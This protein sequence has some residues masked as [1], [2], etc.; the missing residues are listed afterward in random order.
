[1]SELTVGWAE[2][3]I[4]PDGPVTLSGQYY[5]RT[6]TG[7][8]SRLKAVVLAMTSG[9]GDSAVM[10][11]MDV[12]AVPA[13][14]QQQVRERVQELEPEINP[15]KLFLN[16]THTHSAPALSAIR[17]WWLTPDPDCLDPDEYGEMACEKIAQAVTEAW[18]KRCPGGVCRAQAVATVGHCRRSVYADGHA[19]MYG[20]TS[21]PDFTGME[22]NED[23]T[24]EL[25]VTVDADQSPTGVILN[26]SCPSQVMEATYEISSDY[27]GRVRELLKETFGPEFTTLCQIGAA[28]CQSPR[29]LVRMKDHTFWSAAGV[30]ILAQRIAG[31]VREPITS[32]C[33]HADPSPAFGHSVRTL[34]LPMRLATDEEYEQ[35]VN[36]LAELEK[37]LPREKA[38]AQ[39]CEQVHVNEKKSG[40]P[41]PYD[42]KL[43][44]FVLMQNAEAVIKRYEDQKKKTTFDIEHHVLRI[45]DT[46]FVSCPFELFLDYGHRIKAISPAAQ[47]SIIQL[48][49]DHV[50][51]LPTRRAEEFRGYGA[52]IINGDV[53]SE[54]GAELVRHSIDRIR[55]LFEQ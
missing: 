18:Q 33:A 27:M 7:I 35:A 28:G 14:F 22:G 13:R 42:S 26:V 16:A 54:G 5:H 9:N 23:S 10:V 40:R 31:A 52:L 46:A 24:I 55:D 1:M 49:C 21:R 25:L 11:S 30:E 41:G 47:V 17:I 50:G 34:G 20:P 44:H 15:Q 43:H 4:T 36:E 3:D 48:A 2:A 39:F 6:S 29:D 32:A 45:G 19:E 53:G 51:Y 8:H 38:F 37:K 12:A